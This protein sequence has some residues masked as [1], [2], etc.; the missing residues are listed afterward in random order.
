MRN[1]FFF[2]VGIRWAGSVA[3]HPLAPP[4]KSIVQSF[5]LLSV[6]P[7]QESLRC[8][9]GYVKATVGLVDVLLT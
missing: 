2:I 4:V 6:L 7:E 5:P 8:A 9:A 3:D 1:F